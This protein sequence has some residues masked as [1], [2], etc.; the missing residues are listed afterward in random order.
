[1]TGNILATLQVAGVYEMFLKHNT[2]KYAPP[3]GSLNKMIPLFLLTLL[4]IHT[5]YFFLWLKCVFSSLA[6]CYAS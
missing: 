5:L 1:M 3:N 2:F 6:I 4:L